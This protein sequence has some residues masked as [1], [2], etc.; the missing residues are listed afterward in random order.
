MSPITTIK[1]SIIDPIVNQVKKPDHPFWAKVGKNAIEIAQPLGALAIL[2]FV[3]APLKDYAAASWIALCNV[4][5][6]ATKLTTK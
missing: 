4:I 3:P 1:T 2:L 5:K 6:G